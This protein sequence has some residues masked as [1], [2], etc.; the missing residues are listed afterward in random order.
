MGLCMPTAYVLGGFSREPFRICG[1][2]NKSRRNCRIWM[3]TKKPSTDKELYFHTAIFGNI[4]IWHIWAA[5]VFVFL[6]RLKTAISSGYY[7]MSPTETPLV[8]PL[9]SI[10][11]Y[12]RYRFNASKSIVGVLW[13][14]CFISFFG[15]FSSINI[16]SGII[17]YWQFLAIA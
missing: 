12:S 14:C 4:V 9:L 17:L 7:I 1:W 6:R 11:C 5:V 13:G 10:N 3:V 8:C 16:T 15:S 2:Q